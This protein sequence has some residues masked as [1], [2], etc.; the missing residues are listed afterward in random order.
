M[1]VLCVDDDPNVALLL[2]VAL[3][4]A[5]LHTVTHGQAKAA[6]EWLDRLEAVD[7][8]CIVLDLFMPGMGGREFLA[9]LRRRPRLCAMPVIVVSG[10]APTAQDLPAAGTYQAFVAKPF[11]LQELVAL[12]RTMARTAGGVAGGEGAPA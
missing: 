12:V 4:R 10:A 7:V 1:R 8:G 9:H 2:S 3:R 5:G 6:L 11:D